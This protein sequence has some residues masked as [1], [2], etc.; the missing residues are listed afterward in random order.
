MVYF[1]FAVLTFKRVLKSSF[2]SRVL[3]IRVLKSMVLKSRVL[4]SLGT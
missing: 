1:N 3:K 2:E 4:K